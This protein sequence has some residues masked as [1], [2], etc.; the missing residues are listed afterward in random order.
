VKDLL[1][2]V[3]ART[4][5]DLDERLRTWVPRC[6]G[7]A[8]QQLAAGGDVVVLAFGKAARAMAAA[9]VA[10]LPA[11]RVRGLLVPTTGDDA[12]LPPLEV[13]PGGHPL[14]DEGSFRAAK[15]ALALCH[16][17]T[18]NDHVTYLISGG[19]SAMLELPIDATIGVEEWRAFHSRLVGSG[20]PIDRV[21]RI[22]RRLSAVKGGRLAVAAAAAASQTSVVVKDVPGPVDD[23]ASG[24][25]SPFDDEP[26]TLLADLREWHALDAL[27]AGLRA[28]VENGSIPSSPAIPGRLPTWITVLDE[29]HAR[30]S[31]VAQLVTRGFHVRSVR[32]DDWPC[33]RAADD[34]LRRLDRLH[35]RHPGRDV[36]IVTT[37]EL[38]VPLPPDPGRGGRNQQFALACARRIRGMP[39]TV[40]SCGT[41]GIDGNSPAA[42]AIVDGTTMAR[43]RRL[44]LDVHGALRGC[45]AFP[46]LHALG[47]TVITGPTGT[48]V[49]DLRVLVHHS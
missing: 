14:P 17:V 5:A 13:I 35:R 43:A 8:E 16:S 30:H 32:V 6:R 1:R 48:N 3:F 36:A 12:P 23:V 2:Q 10:A 27:P 22:R 38:S 24:P 29:A 19:G 39:I 20:A 46:L 40:L 4:I 18:P 47:D 9:Y 42:G 31:A 26:E 28:A 37:G 49:R 25:T 7:A 21:N 44:G 34:L 45:A 11:G 41:D 15:R 33:E